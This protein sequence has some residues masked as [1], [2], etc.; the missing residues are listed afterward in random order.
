MVKLLVDNPLLLLFVIAAISYP[1]GRVK[2]KG[3][4]LGVAA[5][6]F[7]SIA[8][9]S[10]DPNL[11]LPDVVF[12][13]GAVLFVYTLGLSGGPGFFASF[14]SK[15][16]RDSLFVTAILLLAAG[17]TLVAHFVLHLKPTL[18]AGMYAG[19]L[20]N[21]PALAA[22]V[23]Y[24]RTNAPSAARDTMMAE[25]VIGYSIAYP[26]GVIAMIASILALKRLWKVDY[27]A[28]ARQ[29]QALGGTSRH[30]E[31]RTIHVTKVEPI[32]ETLQELT[33]RYGWEVNFSRL[34]RDCKLSLATAEVRLAHGDL[35]SLVG[36]PEDLE[37]VTAY[38]GEESDEHLELDRSEFDFR[39]MFV[40]NPRVV[41]HRLGD[42]NLTRK[43]GAIATRVRRGDVEM[44][45]H[46]NTVLELGDRV[47]IVARRQ[48][49]DRI[50]RF[51]GDSYRALSEI[52]VLTF[53]LGIAV[54][55]LVGLI[56]IPLPGGL[57]FT[58]GFAG[59]P[60]VVA[61]ILG[62]LGRTGPLVWS[63]PYSANLT[64]RQIGLIMFLAGVGTRAGYAFV[65]TFTQG[66][67]LYLFVAGAIITT[68]TALATLWIGYML[69]KIP[70][71]LLIG[72]LAGLQTQPAVLG[73]ALEQ[74]GNDLPNLGYASMFALAVIVKI[75]VAQLLVA[76]LH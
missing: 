16:L 32:G 30:L 10:L 2:I 63:L 21:T 41:G 12:T 4:S 58:L 15:G 74:T 53:S 24:V 25:P 76:F 62:A 69:L 73:F 17:L 54:G 42:L 55:L 75:I 67:G 28:E 18:T 22:V 13:L 14:R 31:N 45:A 38:L 35:V 70:M 60:L 40:S 71:S 29:L 23:Q 5:V 49:M 33:R 64:L 44:L 51:M 39:R 11:K 9:G 26:M 66:S 65:S 37:Q 47:R 50:A 20:T 72:L 43:Y 57:V 56:P 7:V 3:T 36:S 46:D 8:I 34:K 27:A 6:L 48:D 59:G 68:L 52:D 19:S 1:L 61:L